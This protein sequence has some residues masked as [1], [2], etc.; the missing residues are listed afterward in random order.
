M[1]AAFALAIFSGKIIFIFANLENLR[2]FQICFFT[3]KVVTIN[4]ICLRGL[5]VGAFVQQKR[6]N[7]VW[8]AQYGSCQQAQI[9]PPKLCAPLMTETVYTRKTRVFAALHDFSRKNFPEN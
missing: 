7:L 3:E 5:P 8:M 6:C 2:I 1:A 9:F 4:G